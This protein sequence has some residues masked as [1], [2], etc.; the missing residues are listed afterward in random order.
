MKRTAQPLAAAAFAPFGQVLESP[1]RGLRHD[2]AARLYNAREGATPNLC[3]VRPEPTVPPLSV[4]KL[5]RHPMSS[6]A[7]IPLQVV[8]Y[9]VVVCPPTVDGAP[10]RERIEAFITDGTLGINYEVGVWHHPLTVLDSPG[11]FAVLTWE[12]GG[13]A[14]LA[15]A[16]VEPEVIV[17]IA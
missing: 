14:D 4:T 10:D 8:R 5:E 13:E 3:T 17:A 11:T 6:Q 9:L 16:T 1:R 7:L 12:D 2:H 15:W